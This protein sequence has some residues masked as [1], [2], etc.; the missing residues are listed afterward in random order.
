MDA[1]GHQTHTAAVFVTVG[2]A[3]VRTS[4][5]D[6]EFFVRYIDSLILKTSPGGE[7]NQYFGPGLAEAQSRYR[8]ARLIFGKIAAEARATDPSGGLA[9]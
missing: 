1:H 6:A 7:W 5:A 9:E 8:Q 4:A 3:P 2:R